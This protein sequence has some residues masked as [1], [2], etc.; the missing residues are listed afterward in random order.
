[1]KNKLLYTILAGIVSI[2]VMPMTTTYAS[3]LPKVDIQ[4]DFASFHDVVGGLKGEVTVDT[5]STTYHFS[6]QEKSFE[7]NH[8]SGYAT[9]DGVDEPYRLRVSEADESVTNV[10]RVS[11]VLFE[12]ELYVPIE[13]IERFL[14]LTYEDGNFKNDDEIIF[15]GDEEELV[16]PPVE[17]PTEN[18]SEVE[19]DSTESTEDSTQKPENDSN[20]NGS[21]ETD[22]NAGSSNSGSNSSSGSSNSGNVGN[23]GSS[24]SGNSGSGNTG[25]SNSG[26]NNGNTSSGGTQ[27]PSKPNVDPVVVKSISVDRTSVTMT[28]GGTD[29]ITAKV[30]PFDVPDTSI[31][32]ASNDNNIVTADKHGNLKAVGVGTTTITVISNYTPTVRTTVTVTVNPVVVTGISLNKGNTTLEVGGSLSVGATVSPS[33]ASYKGVKWTSSNTS[34]AT[35]DGNGNVKAVAAGTATITATSTSNTSVKAS[36][37]VTVN[38]PWTPTTFTGDSLVRELGALSDWWIDGAAYWSPYGTWT[39]YNV[40]VN[41]WAGRFAA[42]P[43]LDVYIDVK[44]HN[45]FP[46]ETA[47][48]LNVALSKIIPSGASTISSKVKANATG[49][50]TYN[51]DG[52]KVVVSYGGLTTIYIYGK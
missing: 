27:T 52:R 9:V 10:V 35:V 34:V 51:F 4:G 41:S 40:Q 29:K 12:E 22:G 6:V 31:T 16:T 17:E 23:A 19:T 8:L 49:S 24:N 46:E 1:M 38:K 32:Y 42:D 45:V 28:H 5:E 44:G 48:A 18:P 37:T 11:P 50:E 20:S 43:G 7:L 25:N 33:N 26:S 30:N 39:E 36:F 15:E 21:V 13:F 3:E 14:D 47:K 2:I